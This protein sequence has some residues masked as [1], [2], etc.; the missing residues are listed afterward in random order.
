[1]NRCSRLSV[2]NSLRKQ[3]PKLVE[4]HG[5]PARWSLPKRS[6]RGLSADREVCRECLPC[7]PSDCDPITASPP[8]RVEQ[9]AHGSVKAVQVVE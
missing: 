4:G 5:G 3:I 8:V 1:V 7:L 6:P 9:H 2:G